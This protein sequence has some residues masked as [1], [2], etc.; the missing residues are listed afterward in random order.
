MDPG[1][2]R[3]PR[4]LRDATVTLPEGMVGQPLPGR[5]PGGLLA[6]PDRLPRRRPEPGIHFSKDPAA[7]PDASK[8]GT[9]E[10]TTPLLA[11]TTN[12][13]TNS[14]PTPKPASPL[15]E[16]LQAR[17]TSPSRCENPFGSLLAIYLAV[18]DPKLGIV[19]KLA[20]RVEPDPVTGQLTTVFEE[21]PQLPLEDVTLHL[22]GGARGPLITPLA[23]GD[24]TTTSTLTPWS[25]PEGADATPSDSFQRPRP[26]AA[27]PARAAKPRL[28]NS[29]AFDAGT[30]D[31]QAGAYSPF[32]LKLSREDGT[33][34]LTGIDTLLP[35]GLAGKLA[36][37]AQCSEAQ[38][39][40]AQARSG[41]NEGKRR[42]RIALL[43]AGLQGRHRGRRRR[44]RPDPLLH[45]GHRL[46]GRPLQRRPPEPRDHHPGDRRALRPR[47][48]GHPGRPA[49]R[50]RERPDP[51]RLRPPAD[52]PRR[53]P[54]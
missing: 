36:G 7:C 18:E 50:T 28:P 46:P 41:L 17:S 52:D 11:Q 45:P 5:R 13:S 30:T 35:P 40:Q 22:F 53:H 37:I 25:S 42:A 48:R 14:K 33:Q 24:H 23:C 34:R 3:P 4:Q 9:V 20:G 19:A 2:P 21:N 54:A 49:G 38:I 16:P 27:A 8:L 15:L 12:P 1:G 10:V 43:P 31:P 51:R 32:V 29:P 6:R 47:H 26:P 39:A 44:R